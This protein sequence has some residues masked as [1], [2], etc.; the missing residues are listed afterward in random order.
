MTTHEPV[1][2]QVLPARPVP[3]PGAAPDAELLRNFIGPLEDVHARAYAQGIRTM[4]ERFVA[5]AERLERDCRDHRDAA[6]RA[7]E[8]ED[9]ASASVHAGRAATSSSAAGMIRRTLNGNL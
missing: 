4:S 5:V 9:Y 7:L 1:T 3:L 8:E 2:G 6:A